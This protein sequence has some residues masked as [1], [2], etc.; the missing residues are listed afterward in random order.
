MKP[1]VVSSGLVEQA[2]FTWSTSN[3]GSGSGQGIGEVS[4]GLSEHV[5]WLDSLDLDLLRPFSGEF[6]GGDDGYE[7]WEKLVAVGSLPVG[8]LTVVFRSLASAGRDASGRNRFLVH[9]LVGRGDELDMGS[10]AVDDARWLTAEQ[11]P[12]DRL[13]RLSTLKVSDLTPHRANHDC[14]KLDDEARELLKSLLES[15]AGAVRL[16]PSEA[17]FTTTLLAAIPTA[18]WGRLRV[19]WSVGTEAPVVSVGPI[20]EGNATVPLQPKVRLA[21]LESCAL[22]REVDQI[23]DEIPAAERVWSSFAR[24]YAVKLGY[25][26]SPSLEEKHQVAANTSGSLRGRALAEIAS[27]IGAAAWDERR[28]LSEGEALRVLGCLESQAMDPRNLC[29]RLTL[30]ELRALFGGIETNAGFS[31][32]C[33]FFEIAAVDGDWLV[34]GWRETSLA[35]FGFGALKLVSEPNDRGAWAVPRRLDEIELEKLVG[36]LRRLDGGV[37]HLATLLSAGFASSAEGRRAVI[38]ALEAAGAPAQEIFEIVLPR[39]ALSPR[40]EAEFMREN[41]DLVIEW[42]GVPARS[43]EAFKFGFGRRW[44]SLAS[45]WPPA[46]MFE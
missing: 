2:I 4:P 31:R 15:P 16:Q 12:L 23:W 33:R 9:L 18:L 28:R 19:G 34:R 8:E 45:L 13:P 26:R 20:A 40:M 25:R 30:E 3:L 27:A 29:D 42:L 36:H 46:K 10:V 21:G 32:C 5:P 1:A 43:A 22:H 11:C 37:D 41:L 14:S 35:V 24:A 44:F 6:A 39:A 7:G 17:S 38:D